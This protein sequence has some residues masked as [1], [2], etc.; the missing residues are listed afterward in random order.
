MIYVIGERPDGIVKVGH[1][2]EPDRRL[3]T[4]QIGNST[5][6]RLLA[7]FDG[8]AD[9]EK[10]LHGMFRNRQT[11]GEWFDFTD[12]HAVDQVATALTRGPVPVDL[13]GAERRRILGKKPEV[14]SGRHH[15]M[16]ACP[17]L[18]EI[19]C[20]RDLTRAA[21]AALLL[22]VACS[23]ENGVTVATVDQI[24]DLTHYARPVTSK[25]MHELADHGYIERIRRSMYRVHPRVAIP[26]AREA[27]SDT[28]VTSDD[29]KERLR[30]L[31]RPRGA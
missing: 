22:L 19:A 24:A 28:W 17:T 16:M 8:G 3:R 11:R 23:D 4:L 2:D 21:S 12:S 20:D 29:G 27:R 26:H 7:R 6:L 9:E 25:A 30:G 31:A 15:A 10:A 5:S 14:L 13:R 1:S 18:F